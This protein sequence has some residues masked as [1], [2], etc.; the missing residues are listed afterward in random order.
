[1]TEISIC[2]IPVI[3]CLCFPVYSPDLHSPY[4]IHH[5]GERHGKHPELCL[6]CSRICWCSV[7]TEP[8]SA[9]PETCLGLHA[10]Q[11]HQVSDCH[12]GVPHRPWVHLLPLL[13]A[14]FPLPVHALYAEIQDSRG[15]LSSMTLSHPGHG[16]P[17]WV[18]SRGSGLLGCSYLKV[19][20]FSSKGLFELAGES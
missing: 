20:Y 7:T 15:M 16:Y 13:P 11:L 6:P 19:F 2:I 8:P 3:W 12:L 5:G 14:W 1:M 17:S 9:L 4:V 10:G 18:E